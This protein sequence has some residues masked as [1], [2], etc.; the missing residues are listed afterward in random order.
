M[1][2]SRTVVLSLLVI[3]IAGMVAYATIPK[4]AEPDIEIPVIYINITHDG[5]SPEDGERLLVRPMEQELRTIEGIKEM[6]A[7]AF[8][9]GAFVQIEFEAGVNTNAR[10]WTW[11]SP[12]CPA[13][14]T[15]RR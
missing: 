13:I 7:S 10:K 12:N 8:E 5:I 6:T 4:E 14:R 2:R 9:G 15:S 3:L 1:S 11:R